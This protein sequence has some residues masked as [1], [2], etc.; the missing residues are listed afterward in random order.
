MMGTTTI[1]GRHEFVYKMS[2]HVIG[3]NQIVIIAETV[4]DGAEK[5][6]DYV[7]GSESFAIKLLRRGD[8]ETKV[9]FV[10]DLEFGDDA[11][12]SKAALRNLQNSIERRLYELTAVKMFFEYRVEV[13]DMTER[14]GEALG[15]NMIWVCNGE[16]EQ[17]ETRQSVDSGERHQSEELMSKIKRKTLGAARS[18]GIFHD[19]IKEEKRVEE[20][21]V[22]SKALSTVKTK[23]PWIVV[24]VQRA[25]RGALTVNHSMSKTLN[26]VNENDARIL[27]NNLMPALKTNKTVAAGIDQWRGQNRAVDE[28]L[29]EFPWLK[30]LFVGLGQYVV[31]AAPWG[32]KWR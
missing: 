32:L 7:R 25:R 12:T 9:E 24:L 17:L 18:S 30:G 16:G 6:N 29:T 23:Y 20:V 11:S 4:T 5:S 1:R 27:G 10:T 31:N 2:L 13:A 21:I 14:D 22:K 8:L 19:I 15:H 28:L 3:D 26:C